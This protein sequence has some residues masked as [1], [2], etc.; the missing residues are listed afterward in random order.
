MN[1][2]SRELAYPTPRRGMAKLAQA[3]LLLLTSLGAIVTGGVLCNQRTPEL[4]APLIVAGVLGVVGT[5]LMLRG[6]IVVA[7]NQSKLIVLFGRY[8]GT[9]RD[10]GFFWVNPFASRRPLSLRAHNF[11][12]D[13]LKVNDL[14]GNPIE[15]GDRKSVV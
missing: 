13:K 6:L 7:P 4:G 1:T 9:L 14:R 3:I 15:I 8:T 12:S 5:I 2:T 10:A 11:N